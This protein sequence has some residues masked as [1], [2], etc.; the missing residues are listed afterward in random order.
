MMHYVD[1]KNYHRNK[2]AKTGRER[3][4]KRKERKKLSPEIAEYLGS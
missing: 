1:V 3:G 4:E 2:T